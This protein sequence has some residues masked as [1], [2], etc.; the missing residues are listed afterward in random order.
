MGRP[1][2][3]EDRIATTAAFRPA[4]PPG[5]SWQ[6]LRNR[7][8]RSYV[9]GQAISSP[10]TW[11]QTTALSWLVLQMTD[12]AVALSL[13]TVCQFLPELLFGPLGGVAVD[14]FSRR[15]VMIVTSL[16]S[17]GQALA[18]AILAWTGTAQIWHFYVLSLVTGVANTFGIPA[19]YAYV[20][21]LVDRQDLRGAAALNSAVINA[22]RVVGPSLAILILNPLG[23]GWCFALNAVSWLALVAAV[24]SVRT[25]DLRPQRRS[26]RAGVWTQLV[27]GVQYAA[28]HTNLLFPLA[29][30]AVVGVFGVNFTVTIPLLARFAL[31]VNAEG[32]SALNAALGLGSLVG[33]FTLAPR[34]KPG[35]GIVLL[36][37]TAFSVLLFTLA[38]VPSFA[39][40]LVVLVLLGF[41]NVLYSTMSNNALQLESDE[42][43]RGRVLSLYSW[44][45]MGSTPLGGALTGW[46]VA[47]WNIQAAL[48]F[49]GA[50]CVAACGGALV[51]LRRRRA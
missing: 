34:L 40:A 33:A 11:L 39:P 15:K 2:V 12:S 43:Y 13:V 28:A 19:R 9:I 8:V 49:E 1:S 7:N 42:E 14:R 32:Y 27:Q 25:R 44:L 46:I 18:L 4:P 22:S 3:R 20:G 16:V 47:A 30:V 35:L 36:T 37:G 31:N 45:Y 24:A 48:A 21:E 41:S 10:G 50:V 5:S 38:F 51:F 17:A 26:A 23:A 6:V 29:L